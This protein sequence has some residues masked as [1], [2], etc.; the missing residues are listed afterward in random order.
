MSAM[1]EGRQPVRPAGASFQRPVGD[2]HCPRA[3]SR[4]PECPEDR[5]GLLHRLTPGLAALGLLAVSCVVAPMA[6]HDGLPASMPAPGFAAA[7]FEYNRAY[8]RHDGI[9]AE[10]NEY[11]SG[12]LR[13]GQEWRQ[14]C[15]E[16]GLTVL[17]PG[18]FLPCLQ[19]GVGL[20]EPAV[21]LRA[22]WTPMVVSL[23][24]PPTADFDPMLWWQVSALA[25]TP[26]K[27]RGFGISGG[28]RTSRI[29]IGPV[30]VLDYSHSGVSFRLEGSMTFRTPWANSLVQGRV[31][32]VGLSAEP[33]TE[34][35]RQ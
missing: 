23:V 20:R 21:T 13:F 10:P 28:A 17:N 5:G 16:G 7:R 11:F 24:D 1:N 33:T 18:T 8:W 4:E 12:G 9:S 35:P 19:G 2:V 30:A 25:G 14:F 32:T 29:G 31:L 27:S 3:V 22:L 15:F 34:I 6:Y 26:R